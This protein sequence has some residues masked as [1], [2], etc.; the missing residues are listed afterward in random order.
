MNSLRDTQ[1]NI[2]KTDILNS[3]KLPLKSVHPSYVKATPLYTPGEEKQNLWQFIKIVIVNY[4][5]VVL[6]GVKIHNALITLES[7]NICKV[8]KQE[9]RKPKKI[10][11]R[12]HFCRA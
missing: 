1:G 9:K 7:L 11:K 12:L 10:S 2:S 3:Y 8:N 5:C 6:N 4:H